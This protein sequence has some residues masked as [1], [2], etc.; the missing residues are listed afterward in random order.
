MAAATGHEKDGK[1][2]FM[3]RT[4]RPHI[5]SSIPLK[6]ISSCYTAGR[7]GDTNQSHR[8]VF[9]SREM[10]TVVLDSTKNLSEHHTTPF[11]LTEGTIMAGDLHSGT[12]ACQISVHRITL[13][14]DHKLH[15][16]IVVD[17][18]NEL[19]VIDAVICDPYV[20]V[21]LNDSSLIVLYIRIDENNEV[22]ADKLNVD[23]VYQSSDS[24]ASCLTIYQDKSGLF[25]QRKS[26]NSNAL[27][28]S[29]VV[30]DPDDIGLNDNLP[31][32]ADEISNYFYHTKK[33]YQLN[34]ESNVEK[35]RRLRTSIIDNEFDNWQPQ[36]DSFVTNP[37]DVYPSFFL[38]VAKEDGSLYFFSIPSFELVFV[39]P[40]A[41]SVWTT[42]VDDPR[43]A[44]YNPTFGFQTFDEPKIKRSKPMAADGIRALQACRIC[45]VSLYGTGPNGSRPILGVLVDDTITFYE[46]FPFD[47]FLD[48]HLMIRFKK[49]ERSIC[50]RRQPFI[51]DD[52][53]QPVETIIIGS[54]VRS[55]YMNFVPKMGTMENVI[56]AIGG[57]PTVLFV[58][59]C[60]VFQ[61][62][63]S[64]DG[65]IK[66]FCYLCT[67][68]IAHGFV[69]VKDD[70]IRIG[71]TSTRF[72][73][74][75]YDTPYPCRIVPIGSNII[76]ITFIFPFNL[77][78]IATSV[79]EE[80]SSI[81]SV[82]ND[83]HQ[84][85]ECEVDDGFVLPRRHK[86]S[87]R[88]FT[89]EDYQFIPNT[90]LEFKDFENILCVEE[91]IVSTL[92]SKTGLMNYLAIGTAFNMGEEVPARGRLLIYEIIEVVPEIGLPT[93]R[94]KLKTLAELDQKGPVTS[95]SS[96]EGILMV[97]IG[98][99]VFIYTI[100]DEGL[101]ANSFL[102]L[103]FYVTQICPLRSIALCVDMF[104]SVH[105][106]RYQK[107]FKVLSKIATD[108][109]KVHPR[110]HR[111]DFVVNNQN[112]AIVMGD[113]EKNLLVF[114]HDPESLES[115]SSQRLL[116]KGG[117]RNGVTVT[118]FLRVHAHVSDS[119]VSRRQKT[120]NAH[121]TMFSTKE[122]SWGFVRPVPERSYRRL[123]MLQNFIE[124]QFQQIGGLNTRGCRIVRPQATGSEL[125]F[126]NAKQL[127]DGDL[128]MQFFGLDVHDKDELSRRLGTT[129]Y[130]ITD[131]LI[132]L[133]RIVR[134]F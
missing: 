127:I 37:N 92:G 100:K 130:Q 3:E 33:T 62:Q 129:K 26:D 40:N 93:T 126:T 85:Q 114:E 49:I 34:R 110:P 112:V 21:L 54:K 95:I 118:N 20:A 70:M 75:Q 78:A 82:N 51:I 108:D 39:A 105:L 31:E 132:E 98:Q 117:I 36:I 103:N 76:D 87:L 27:P 113:M 83:E 44:K 71:E 128:L 60:G 22:K 38:I 99:R 15:E 111:V 67:P 115:K 18:E 122:G 102:D 53:R 17:S 133:T 25:V 52:N 2:L 24:K 86:F 66:G 74:V 58:G 32:N 77:F 131:D 50:V 48:N 43:Y 55:R 119:M 41:A 124:N 96:T 29:I 69:Y 101:V 123:F 121:S 94:F 79:S 13:V 134:H 81:W 5:G 35:N 4:V 11:C 7:L 116:V 63:F 47:N 68:S 61:H 28:K 109:R 80:Y 84:E 91:V 12:V 8:Y 9:L 6:G 106:L 1:L 120:Y 45:E 65:A 57:Y 88:L 90:D 125:S 72:P 89:R 19:F 73:Q 56:I 104:E 16:E 10:N 64:I 14:M 107:D 97:A 46:A 30:D 42:L 23:N 59:T